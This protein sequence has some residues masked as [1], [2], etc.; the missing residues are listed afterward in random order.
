VRK[1]LRPLTPYLRP[2]ACDVVCVTRRS[3]GVAPRACVRVYARVL[4]LVPPNLYIRTMMHTLS[5]PPLCRDSRCGLSLS[6]LGLSLE[7]GP[8]LPLG[9]PLR[10]L[11]HLALVL[12]E[13]LS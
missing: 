7:L 5:Q 8:R 11:V 9:P 1:A 13:D 4:M 10:L 2:C 6:Q 12:L 3:F